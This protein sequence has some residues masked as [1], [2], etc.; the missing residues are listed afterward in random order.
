MSRNTAKWSTQPPD[1]IDCENMVFAIGED[2]GCV[3]DV[4]TS[5]RTAGLTLVRVYARGPS[6][7]PGE[8]ARAQ[9]LA[10][11]PTKSTTAFA[12]RLWRLLFDVYMQLD[13][14]SKDSFG[15]PSPSVEPRQFL[16][17]RTKRS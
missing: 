13:A 2:F 12:A 8:R 5:W 4:Q 10:E 17:W 7:A 9:A 14:F 11:Y 6:D 16:D 1:L 3:I 15:L